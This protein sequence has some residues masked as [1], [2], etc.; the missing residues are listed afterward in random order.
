MSSSS[1]KEAMKKASICWGDLK[2]GDLLRIDDPS[3]AGPQRFYLV[4]DGA[5]RSD[6]IRLVSLDEGEPVELP[7]EQFGCRSLRDS[8]AKL[9]DMEARGWPSLSDL[10]ARFGGL[11]S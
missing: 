2:T 11:K 1:F 3:G 4:I 5:R 6:Y 10:K 9:C 8:R 7:R